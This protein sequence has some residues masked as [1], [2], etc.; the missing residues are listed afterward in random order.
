MR[1]TKAEAQETRTAIL[2]A[3]LRVFFA[4]GVSRATLEEVAQAAGVTRGAVYW[5]FRN[6]ADLF[7]AIHE[8]ARMPMQDVLACLLAAEGE[9]ALHE[10]EAF[11][12]ETFVRLHEDEQLR[13]FFTVLL[14]KCEASGEMESVLDRLRASKA[15]IVA[16]Q[17]AFFARL[18]KAGVLAPGPEPRTLAVALYAYMTGLFVD[19][20]RSPWSYQMPGDAAKLVGHFFASL[21]AR[22]A[23]DAGAAAPGASRAGARET[24]GAG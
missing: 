5:H 4:R 6:K 15:E 9:S 13:C 23:K 10:L 17:T 16:S 21:R 3:A 2:E 7:E 18:Q 20:L 8:R 19:Y 12:T 22:P 14:L 11:C 24:A 1:R